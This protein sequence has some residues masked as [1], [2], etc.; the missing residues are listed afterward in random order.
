[1]SRQDRR[2]ASHPLGISVTA[3]L[4]AAVL[5]FLG[6][7][8][9]GSMRGQER[10]PSF[11]QARAPA[12]TLAANALR[13][14]DVT[15][16]EA[17]VA[18]DMHVRSL[19]KAPATLSGATATLLCANLGKEMTEDASWVPVIKG[20]LSG[21]SSWRP[22]ELLGRALGE[23][24]DG[25]GA[26][27]VLVPIVIQLRDC[28]HD[29]ATVRDADGKSL[30]TVESN[31]TRCRPTTQLAIRLFLLDR[32]GVILWK[33]WARA[34][35]ARGNIEEGVAAAFAGVP[36]VYGAEPVPA[37]P[38]ATPAQPAQA[39]VGDAQVTRGASAAGGRSGTAAKT[40]KSKSPAPLKG[41]AANKAVPAAR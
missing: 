7:T 16:A 8:G 21:T 4:P 14:G 17:T 20:G 25:N 23:L 1:M 41:G 5:A 13:C 36:A 9:C 35:T 6:A 24:L 10:N 30:G 19:S 38:V 40:T 31:Q 2:R 11:V 39:T 26:E 29:S 15:S 12:P 3:A 33:S 27:S 32:A 22:S 37:A 34:D 18:I 28:G